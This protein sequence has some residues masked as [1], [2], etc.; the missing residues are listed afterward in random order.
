MEELNLL[1]RGMLGDKVAGVDGI[2]EVRVHLLQLTS[3]MPGGNKVTGIKGS[4][5][6]QPSRFQD[7][8]GVWVEGSNH[9]DFPDKDPSDRPA[10]PAKL[11][12]KKYYNKNRR[13]ASSR[14][15]AVN[16]IEAARLQTRSKICVERLMQVSGYKG[17]FF[18]TCPSPVDRAPYPH[19]RYIR[20]IGPSSARNDVMHLVLQNN[21]SNLWRL[22]SGVWKDSNQAPHK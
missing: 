6:R 9:H 5:G 10:S 11:F 19:M 8:H 2:Q 14:T 12:E 17:Y 21:V 13:T 20:D 4:N 18:M 1:A 3:E 22:F 16:I 7:F 15:E